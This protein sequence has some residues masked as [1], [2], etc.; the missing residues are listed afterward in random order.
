MAWN[1]RWTAHEVRR[2]VLAYLLDGLH[3][4]GFGLELNLATLTR[5]PRAQTYT[6]RAV[7]RPIAA[8]RSWELNDEVRF[9][10]WLEDCSGLAK[11][12]G[13]TEDGCPVVDIELTTKETRKCRS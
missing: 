2:F 11:L 3:A 6:A 10:A 4:N 5:R 12:V 1:D 8:E 9:N 13:R 7:I